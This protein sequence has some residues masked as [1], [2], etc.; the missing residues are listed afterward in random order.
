MSLSGTSTRNVG[1]QKNRG[2]RLRHAGATFLVAMGFALALSPASAASLQKYVSP[3]GEVRDALP[4]VLVKYKDGRGPA[5]RGGALKKMGVVRTRELGAIAVDVVAVPR[6]Q[7]LQSFVDQLN[8]DPDIEFAEPNGVL[9]ANA[10]P[11]DPPND[12]DFQSDNQYSLLRRFTNV[13]DAWKIS[14]GI[15]VA[16]STGVIVAVLDSGIT[17]T[18]QDLDGSLWSNPA[19]SGNSGAYGTQIEINWDGDAFCNETDA[20]LGPEQCADPN[21]IDDNTGEFHGTRVSGIIAAETNNTNNIAG[22][23]PDAQIMAVKVLNADG[24]GDFSAVAEGILYAVDNGAQVINMSL[25]GSSASNAV[26]SAVEYAID[27]N[28]VVVAA[29]GNDGAGRPVNFPA[30]IADVIAV[31]ATD[32]LNR[33]A[34]FSCTGSPI[35]LVAPGVS[36]F[37]T[38]PPNDTSDELTGGNDGTSFASPIVA[39][40]AALIRAVAPAISPAQVAKYINFTATDLGTPG[41]DT[42]YGHGLVNAAR[43]VQSALDGD[44]VVAH[45]GGGETNLYPNPY[46]PL[47]VA[48]ATFALPA[49][50]GEDGIEIKIYNAAG[51]LVKTLTGTKFWDGKNDDGSYLAPGIYFYFAKTSRGDVNGKLTIK[52]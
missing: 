19:P 40:V 2:P 39:G 15:S 23:A 38:I 25:G 9:R 12:V 41:P 27:N 4:Q 8:R 31:G 24:N 28:V 49:A 17:P 14:T 32:S 48:Q 30:S 50:L 29:T 20:F 47:Q 34:F 16:N 3:T 52:Q 44:T 35:D 33:L 11:Q 46:N 42:S 21:P 10:F 36:V 51:E 45:S 22:V 18:H 37:S 1:P 7:T 6:G 5:V 43:A 26:R 13:E